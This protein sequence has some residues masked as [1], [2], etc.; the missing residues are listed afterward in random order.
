MR[1]FVGTSGFSYKEWRPGFYPEKMSDKAFLAYY[2]SKLPVVEINSTFY[3]F[4]SKAILEGWASQTPDDFLFTLKAPGGITHRSRL[5]GTTEA[6]DSLFGTVRSLGRRLGP[7]IF[8][9]PP[10][11]KKDLPRLEEALR[12]FPSDVRATFEFRNPTW[13]DDDVKELLATKNVALCLAESDEAEAGDDLTAPLI[14][15]ANWGYLRLRRSD[16]AE[17]DLE[18]WAARIAAQKW[19]EVFVF[20]KHEEAAAPKTALKLQALIVKAAAAVGS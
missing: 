3:R 14:S 13:L 4:P 9:L 16:Y 7:V 18:A 12:T 11:M 5:K 2:A 15:T 19:R 20:V 6:I 10:N 1:V 17:A 8:G